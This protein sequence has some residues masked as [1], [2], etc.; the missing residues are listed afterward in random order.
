MTASSAIAKPIVIGRRITFRAALYGMA[1]FWT[2]IALFPLI[3]MYY[4][5]L[6]S[7]SEY[8]S[9]PWLPTVHPE[10]RN[11]ANAWNGIVGSTGSNARIDIPISRYFVNSTVVVTVSVAIAMFLSSLAAYALARRPVP[12]KRIILGLL[13]LSLVV[14]GH[15]LLLPIYSLEQDLGLISSYPGLILPYV[16]FSVPFA[17]VLLVAYF[18]T[19]PGELEEAARIDGAS[20]LGIFLRIVLPMSKGPLVAVGVLTANALWNEFLYALV[21]MQDPSMRTL[22]PGILSFVGEYSTPFNL[23]LAGMVLSTTPIIVLY[24][25]F[26]RHLTRGMELGTV[27]KG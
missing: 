16:S 7:S 2:V 12:G 24:L 22:P 19:F 6:K 15:A 20:T 3:W 11:Y 1:G 5:S 10:W 18:K 26:Q 4:S 17:V 21:L 14:P 8:V 23:V 9:N 27:L 25:V 13:V